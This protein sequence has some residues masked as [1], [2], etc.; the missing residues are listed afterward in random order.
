MYNFRQF[1]YSSESLDKM[2]EIHCTEEMG[3]GN[4]GISFLGRLERAIGCIFDRDITC[5]D[6]IVSSIPQGIGECEVGSRAGKEFEHLVILAELIGLGCP[7]VGVALHESHEINAVV[8]LALK[9][10]VALVDECL[11]SLC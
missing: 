7:Q 1:H 11:V 8:E 9:A 2:I 10:E 6:T 4:L 5:S 3:F